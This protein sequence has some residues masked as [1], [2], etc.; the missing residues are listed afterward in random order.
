MP[1]NATPA[2]Q[3][4]AANKALAEKLRL[5]PGM[6]VQ[7]RSWFS[8]ISKDLEAFYSRTGTVPDASVYQSELEGILSRQYRRTSNAFSSDV[9]NFLKEA[10]E[11]DPTIAILTAFAIANGI[12][13]SELINDMDNEATVRQQE[14]NAVNIAQDSKSIIGT[15]Q[16][17]LDTSIVF[18]TLFLID[19]GVMN[20]S[21][22]QVAKASRKAFVNSSSARPN[23]IATTVTQKAA[24]G[25]KQIE[26]DVFFENRNRGFAPPLRRQELWITRGDEKVRISHVQADNTLKNEN[27]VFIVAGEQLK[28]PGDRSLGASAGNVINCRCA[29][30]LVIDDSDTPLTVFTE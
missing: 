9:T 12:D 24:E 20:P 16:K 18:G 26:F 30:V 14:F 28:M 7:L 1:L 27:G 19:Q 29:S 21:R 22:N 6:I 10:D 3:Q 23:T 11:D 17:D 5:E 8:T 4:A 25:T 2:E 13:L 15:T